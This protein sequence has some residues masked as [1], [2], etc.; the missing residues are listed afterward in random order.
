MHLIEITLWYWICYVHP[1]AAELHELRLP[2]LTS[3]LVARE[4]LVF[5]VPG[6]R[7][8]GI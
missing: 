6:L 5:V 8:A 1:V 4:R 3:Q 2:P 7:R